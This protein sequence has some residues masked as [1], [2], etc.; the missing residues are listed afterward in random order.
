[1]NAP[2]DDSVLVAVMEHIPFRLAASPNTRVPVG[3]SLCAAYGGP[4]RM[5]AR[6]A[7]MEWVQQLPSTPPFEIGDF[8]D[9]PDD[10]DESDQDSIDALNDEDRAA[11]EVYAAKDMLWSTW[12][13]DF[14]AEFDS[15][16]APY[17]EH[18]GADYLF[19]L[20][21][22][23]GWEDG[24]YGPD[25]GPIDPSSLYFES[26][27]DVAADTD[28]AG[29]QPLIRGILDQGTASVLYGDTN[30]GKTFLSLSMAYAI[31]KGIPWA[32]RET[33]QKE[34]RLYRGRRRPRRPETC[35]GP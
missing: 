33:T 7:F 11:Y 15:F 26:F 5:V 17:E 32:G 16:E 31:S 6:T 12:L 22:K 9:L 28:S 25:D 10:F 14:D 35:P 34:R 24:P 18:E 27:D 1:M 19:R 21:A 30:L 23:H 20:A 29:N 3:R 13:R 4:K 2:I 8:P